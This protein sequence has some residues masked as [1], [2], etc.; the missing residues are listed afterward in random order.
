M[1]GH[2]PSRASIGLAAVLCLPMVAEASGN[3][4]LE[5]EP[6]ADHVYAII[7][8]TGNRSPENLANNATFGFVVTNDGVVLIDSGGSYKGAAAIEAVIRKVTDKP[9]TTVINTGGQDHRW[10]GNGYFKERGA[11]IIASARAVEDQRTREQDQY[12][13]LGNLIGDSA[14]EGTESVFADDTFEGETT[15]RVG[16]VTFELYEVG[17][18]H[19]PGDVLV[20]MPQ[21][22]ILFTGDV[23]YVRRML[24]VNSY[25]NNRHWISAFERVAALEPDVVVPGHGPVTNLDRARADTYDYLVFL[26]ESV[27]TFME[28]GG[29]IADIGSIDQSRFQYLE[30]FDDLAGRNAQQVYTELEWE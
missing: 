16:E 22:R 15:R 24:G 10:L 23:V 19:T 17:P 2:L 18:A 30:N 4:A 6:I 3:T 20:W 11:R 5:L 13:A 1:S 14:L 29:N 25:S 12:F 26:R 28:D 7:G 8:P 9:I 27:G 21:E